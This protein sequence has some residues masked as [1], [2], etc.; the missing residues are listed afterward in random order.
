MC[1]DGLISLGAPYSLGFVALFRKGG[2]W[3]GKPVD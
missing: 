3:G 1:A 2:R